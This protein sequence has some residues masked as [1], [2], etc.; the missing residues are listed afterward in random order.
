MTGRVLGEAFGASGAIAV[1][2]VLGTADVDA[3]TV[4]L[5]KLAPATISSTEAAIA[6]LTAVAANTL[7]KIGLCTD[8]GRGRFVLLTAGM[9][10]ACILAGGG[11][12][13]LTVQALSR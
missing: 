13:W 8:L 9:G 7:S 1:A 11:A 10:I 5:S 12:L 3:L 6:I 2:A 4:S